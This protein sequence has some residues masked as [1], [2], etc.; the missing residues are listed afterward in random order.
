MNAAAHK[1]RAFR[2][3]SAQGCVTDELAA[4]IIDCTAIDHRRQAPKNVPRS[5]PQKAETPAGVS[6]SSAGVPNHRI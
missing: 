5:A 6:S 1:F 4:Q 2:P 3:P